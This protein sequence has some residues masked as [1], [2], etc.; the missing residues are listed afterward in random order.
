[1]RAIQAAKGRPLVE[2]CCSSMP[3]LQFEVDGQA[4]SITSGR[5]GASKQLGSDARVSCNWAE[6]RGHSAVT[7]STFRDVR[8]NGP[9]YRKH[10]FVDLPEATWT[11]GMRAIREKEAKHGLQTAARVFMRRDLSSSGSATGSS[12]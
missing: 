12:F 7:L 5:N 6:A 1:M 2:I 4:A 3:G 11:P 10:G 9:F 8:W